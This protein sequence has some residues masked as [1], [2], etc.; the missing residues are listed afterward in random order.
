MTVALGHEAVGSD[1]GTGVEELHTSRVK[2][3]R[4]YQVQRTAESNHYTTP[5]EITSTKLSRVYMILSNP[6]LTAKAVAID[7]AVC[8]TYS[9]RLDF[10]C[11][12]AKK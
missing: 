5:G 2:M 1:F 12:I 10:G 9:M 11:I 4:M 7:L 8:E 3:S 6:Q